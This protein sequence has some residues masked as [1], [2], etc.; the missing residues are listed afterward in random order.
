MLQISLGHEELQEVHTNL[1]INSFDVFKV[2]GVSGAQ[3]CH[4]ANGV[5][6]ASCCYLRNHMVCS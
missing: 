6:V 2:A 1:P 4:Y 3:H 5:L